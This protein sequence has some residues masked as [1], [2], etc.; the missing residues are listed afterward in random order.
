MRRTTYIRL[1]C[2]CLYYQLLCNAEIFAG[3][4]H[5]QISRPT[6]TVVHAYHVQNF[7]QNHRNPLAS[8]FNMLH[9][10]VVHSNM[11]R[12]H[13]MSLMNASNTVS[14]D[15]FFSL[16]GSYQLLAASHCLLMK[17]RQDEKTK[18]SGEKW[19]MYGNK[20]NNHHFTHVPWKHYQKALKKLWLAWSYR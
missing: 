17:N 19:G 6:S 9:T 2:L 13:M 10:K 11:C 4:R 3:Y 16:I 5:H 12:K 8:S 7:C 15:I 20:V 18:Q 14:E 1:T